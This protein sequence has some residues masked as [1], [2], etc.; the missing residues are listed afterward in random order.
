MRNFHL[1]RV[2]LEAEANIAPMLSE[3]PAFKTVLKANGQVFINTTI[4]TRS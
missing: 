3:L 1:I 2:L 4:T